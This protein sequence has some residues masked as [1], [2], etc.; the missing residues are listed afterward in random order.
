[1]TEAEW[2]TATN[3]TPML[4]FMRGKASDRKLRLFGVECCRRIWFL[5]PNKKCKSAVEAAE[6]YA[7]GE[8]EGKVLQ[9]TSEAI[10]SAIPKWKTIGEVGELAADAAA[11]VS[12]LDNVSGAAEK[13]SYAHGV[14]VSID[15]HGYEQQLEQAQQTIV[16]RD[17]FGNPFRPIVANSSWLTSNVRTLAEGIY[18]ERAFDRMPILADALQ[19]A[20]CDNNDI[21]N[22]C[23]QPGEHV[24]GCWVVDLILGKS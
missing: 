22:H 9:A 5:L 23:R 24:R 13:A 12:S 15:N 4:V 6:R 10:I 19:D 8:C 16:F 1:M 17:I 21:L 20:G 3:P 11:C 2:L 18:E 14:K 7:D